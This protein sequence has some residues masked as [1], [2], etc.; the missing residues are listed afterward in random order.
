MMTSTSSPKRDH[1]TSEQI[2]RSRAIQF[3]LTSGAQ[4]IDLLGTASG[5]E[6]FAL[7]FAFR[8]MVLD[9]EIPPAVW[10]L[11]EV[12]AALNSPEAN[13]DGRAGPLAARLSTLGCEIDALVDGGRRADER[14]AAVP[15][16]A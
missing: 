14:E 12:V 13:C 16:A 15:R 1:S 3:L 6:G 2:V 9:Q 7:G 8:D 10:P 5:E 11:A 4:V